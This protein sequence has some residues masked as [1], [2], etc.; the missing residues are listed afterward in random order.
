MWVLPSGQKTTGQTTKWIKLSTGRENNS[1]DGY[2]IKGLRFFGTLP[3]LQKFWIDNIV[4]LATVFPKGTTFESLVYQ[5]GSDI[6]TLIED[7]S[8]KMC[9]KGTAGTILQSTEKDVERVPRNI[10]DQLC[11]FT[12]SG[13]FAKCEV[14]SITDGDTFDV[15]MYVPFMELAT[16]KHLLHGKTQ[17][18]PIV[19][20]GGHHEIGFFTRITIRAYGYDAIEKDKPDGQL[21]KQVL[22]QKFATLRNIIWCQF[23][24]DEKYGRTLAL[25]YEDQAKVRGLNSYLIDEGNK[26]GRRLA[27]PY[28]GGTKMQ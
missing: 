5:P 12:F 26:M 11:R 16:T 17:Q 20:T 4:E 8:A 18:A 1:P 7:M 27:Y 14:V 2:A 24:D 10:K 25:M 28:T 23:V 13:L 15:I 3:E 9:F 6:N 22:T 19:A 21:A